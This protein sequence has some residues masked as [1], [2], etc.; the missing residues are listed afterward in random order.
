MI[1]LVKT[2]SFLHQ[3][4]PDLLWRF[5]TNEKVLYLTFDDG[6]HPLLT[7]W[8][9]NC[10]KQFQAKATFFCV[11]NN[12]EKYPDVYEQIISEG[13]HV[14]NH[15]HNHLRGWTTTSE[16][17][18]DNVHQCQKLVNSTL[19]RPPYGRITPKQIRQLK[20]TYK[21]VM[22]DVL[23][24]DFSQQTPPEKCLNNVIDHSKSG[25]IIVFHDNKNAE[26][27]MKHALPLILS[28]FSKLGYCFEVIPY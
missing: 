1:K 20:R 8:V 16:K 13:H 12:V 14:G 7:P 28:H 25:S 18:V 5:S 10:L 3:L 27:N 11:G 17:Y 6:P 22:W 9:L 26:E 21:I 24:W 2:P 15:T 19:F 23:S 4:F